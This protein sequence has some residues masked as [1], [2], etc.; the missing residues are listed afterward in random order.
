MSNLRKT[1]QINPNLFK[2][3]N[4]SRKNKDKNKG[5]NITPIISPNLLKNKLLK[6]IKEHKQTSS[7]NIETIKYT[8]EFNDSLEYL[9]SLSI[10]K[11]NDEN[12][13]KLQKKTI[14]NNIHLNNSPTLLQ[15]QNPST[16]TAIQY[17][18]LELPQELLDNPVISESV[19]DISLS[20]NYNNINSIQEIPSYIKEEP[21]NINYKIDTDVPYGCLKNGFK[22][23]YRNYKSSS[24]QQSDSTPQIYT[25][26]EYKLNQLRE[27]L[28]QTKIQNENSQLNNIST[29]IQTLEPEP[30]SIIEPIV[31]SLPY[32]LEDQPDPISSSIP[33]QSNSH[34]IDQIKQKIKK[35]TKR[36]YKLGKS[37]TQRV[38]GILIKNKAT[39]L[40]VLNAYKNLK[41]T[42]INDVKKY[43]NEQNMI[44]VG[45]N[46][47]HN[48]HRKMYEML[49]L[50]GDIHNNNKDI[51][52][53]NFL[54]SDGEN[55]S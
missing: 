21:I 2:V 14:R 35:T 49:K 6:K 37:K 54:K 1:I 38:V 13:Q 3:G 51:M 36:K 20:N 34:H 42:P 47:P 11:K 22:K 16:S 41:K 29:K 46:A 5:P 17:V 19:P 43:L 4:K 12:K 25:S 18:E 23:T 30:L 33:T 32:K 7:E 52:L 53:H 55:I 26:R 50:S 31:L 15:N 10:K 45:S 48:V 40:E 28:K 44:M 39:R 8:D 27:K 24:N 9:Q